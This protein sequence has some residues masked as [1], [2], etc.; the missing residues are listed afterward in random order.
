MEANRDRTEFF[1]IF[2]IYLR[3]GCLS[4]GGPVAHLGYF[5]NEFVTRLRWLDSASYAELLTLCQF[6]PGPSS[7]QLGFAIGWHRGGLAGACAAWLGFTL[8]SAVMMIGFAYGLFALGTA[9]EP[10]SH[11]LLIA[12]V[13]VVA[14]AT[15]GLGQKL[16]PDLPRIAIAILAA[17]IALNYSN[18]LSPIAAIII[19]ALIAQK[20]KPKIEP[21]QPSLSTGPK[22]TPKA[23]I[24]AA[25]ILYALL[26]LLS[27]LIE[28]STPGAIYALHYRAG[29]SSSAVAMLCFHYSTI[30]LL[31]AV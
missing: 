23:I 28:P 9:V 3:L 22:A 25:L 20:L 19:G 4:F 29:H 26:L 13:A 27:L 14:H 2:F 24:L 16:C 30:A 18:N 5:K 10:L 15:L 1:K 6:V 21:T 8:P 12:A 7:S 11:G 31:Q 17:A